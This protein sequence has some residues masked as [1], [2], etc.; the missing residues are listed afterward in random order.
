MLAVLPTGFG[1]SLCYFTLPLVFD[2]LREDS[3][4]LPTIILVITLLTALMKDQ[5]RRYLF[6]FCA[7]CINKFAPVSNSTNQRSFC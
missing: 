3:S 2:E 5:V 4:T 6:N 1:K 7:N